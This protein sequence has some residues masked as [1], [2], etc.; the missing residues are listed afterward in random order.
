MRSVTGQRSAAISLP[1]IPCS[2]SI[3]DCPWARQ[4]QRS[5]RFWIS[6]QQTKR[7]KEHY[8]PMV[9][10]K[11]YA[12]TKTGKAAAAKAKKKSKKKGK[13]SYG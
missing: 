2:V 12:Y 7:N 9:N 6:Y 11:K 3:Q 4:R 10:G 13:K 1:S 8:M 5:D